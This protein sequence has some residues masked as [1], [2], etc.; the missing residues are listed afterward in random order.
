MTVHIAK[1]SSVIKLIS[2]PRK[3]RCCCC[4][5]PVVVV[6]EKILCDGRRVKNEIE[7]FESL[8]TYVL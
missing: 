7:G 4:F 6:D 1:I 5:A 3:F 2:F 8:G